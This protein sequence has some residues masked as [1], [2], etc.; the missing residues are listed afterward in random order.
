M[1]LGWFGVPPLGGPSGL[2]RLKPELQAVRGFIVPM[3]AE[4]NQRG[5]SKNDRAAR[6][7]SIAMTAAPCRERVASR[8]RTR[9]LRMGQAE[10]SGPGTG[11]TMRIPT[12]NLIFFAGG[13]SLGASLEPLSTVDFLYFASNLR[14]R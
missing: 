1:N 6:I 8:I 10:P 13:S 11:E 4:K 5:L 2:D 3:H 7:G 12:L 9:L 14:W